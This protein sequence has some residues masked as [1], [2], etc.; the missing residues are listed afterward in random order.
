MVS[1][2]IF[3]HMNCL[4]K[5]TFGLIRQSL[6][7][8]YKDKWCNVCQKLR[9]VDRDFPDWDFPG[10]NLL[11]LLAREEEG[12]VENAEGNLTTRRA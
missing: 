7:K 11:I 5:Y 8:S 6:D 2:L 1:F 12:F 10:F 4:R 9:L 3:I